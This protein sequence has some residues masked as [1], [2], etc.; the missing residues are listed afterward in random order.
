MRDDEIEGVGEPST[1]WVTAYGCA[2]SEME[3]LLKFDYI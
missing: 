1:N 2:S 3:T